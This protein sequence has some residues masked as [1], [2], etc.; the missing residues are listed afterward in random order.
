VPSDANDRPEA[1]P[2]YLGHRRR[3]R[4][5]YMEG[6]A[7]A[8]QD[9]ELL[10]LVLFAAIPRRDV[11]PLAKSLLREFGGL[12]QVANAPA[13]RLVEAGLGETAA[14][15]V[16][17]IGAVALRMT[18]RQLL[19]RPVLSSWQRLID[20]CEA[21]MADETTEQ[22]RLLF[23]DRKNRLIADEIQQRGT[24]DHAPVYPREIVKRAL[25]L[26]ASA[27]ILVHNHPSGD[28]TPSRVDIDMTRE[29][30]AA[31]AAVGLVVHD[32]V[33]VGRGRHFSFKTEGLL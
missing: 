6:G 12:W 3:L 4:A 22:L 14:V 26:D 31:A 30:A 13:S 2:H 7:A 5:R 9:Y 17:V 24:V 27:V 11:K 10:E 32:H 15:A 29:V 19:N 1:A 8:L 21:A 25:E 20:Y 33:V 18:R 16:S 23:L 28:P